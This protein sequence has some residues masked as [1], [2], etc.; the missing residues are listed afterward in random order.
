MMGAYGKEKPEWLS[1]NP[2]NRT[3]T[4][5]ANESGSYRVDFIYQDDVGARTYSNMRITVLPR[6]TTFA[7]D[8]KLLISQYLA[9]AWFI[10]MF[11][12]LAYFF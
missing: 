7:S 10:A 11:I 8:S 9:L 6:P 3:L 5:F 2:D 4:G 12:Y 1:Y